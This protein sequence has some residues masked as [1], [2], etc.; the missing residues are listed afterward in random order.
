MV[1]AT[2]SSGYL[3]HRRGSYP[4]SL[5]YKGVY[6]MDNTMM[7]IG[8]Y[9]RK[10]RITEL[11]LTLKEVEGSENIKAL[12]SFEHGR[13][14]NIKHLIKYVRCCKDKEQRILFLQ[15]LIDV[16][17]EGENNGR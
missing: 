3:F 5:L 17:D 15:G 9:C 7:K 4:F 12:S 10:F 13:S 1:W 14:T 2:L 8:K 11:E 6:M 16:L